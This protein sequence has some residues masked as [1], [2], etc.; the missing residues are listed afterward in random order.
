MKLKIVAFPNFI[1]HLWVPACV[2]DGFAPRLEGQQ[3]T[4][5]AGSAV[6]AHGCWEHGRMVETQEERGAWAWQGGMDTT[7][8]WSTWMSGA[9]AWPG[10]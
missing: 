2:E 10:A 5:V 7:T 9:W 8:A 4:G 3:R 1:S 6:G